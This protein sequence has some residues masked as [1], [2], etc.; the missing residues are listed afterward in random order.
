MQVEYFDTDNDLLGSEEYTQKSEALLPDLSQGNDVYLR[1]VFEGTN[2]TH[3]KVNRYE[4]EVGKLNVFVEAGTRLG[5]SYGQE[6][7]RLN[8]MPSHMIQDWQLVEVEFGRHTRAMTKPNA[9]EKDGDFHGDINTKKAQSG[10][11]GGHTKT[12]S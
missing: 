3:W 8:K 9:A 12:C 7:D 6:C 5:N 1:I 11:P 2:H 4:L 10:L